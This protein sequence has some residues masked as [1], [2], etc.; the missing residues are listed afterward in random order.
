[1]PSG[2]NLECATAAFLERPSLTPGRIW[3]LLYKL[4]DVDMNE[5]KWNSP[6]ML[7]VRIM[8]TLRYVN[9]ALPLTEI[10]P[11]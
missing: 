9:H 6:I 11:D 4:A 10:P 1:M 5:G 3:Q 7:R 2:I 8:A